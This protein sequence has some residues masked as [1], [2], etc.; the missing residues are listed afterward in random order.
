MVFVFVFSH[1][2]ECVIC[3][4]IPPKSIHFSISRYSSISITIQALNIII[5]HLMIK[6]D[7]YIYSTSYCCPSHLTLDG[8]IIFNICILTLTIIF[9]SILIVVPGRMHS[10]LI[11]SPFAVNF[12][13]HQRKTEVKKNSKNHIT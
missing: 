3:S 13:T 7:Q 1:S 12:F 2:L 5:I 4:L 9:T 11:N 8:Y 6:I 10:V